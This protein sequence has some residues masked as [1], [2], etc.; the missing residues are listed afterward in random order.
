MWSL[1]LCP[2][3]NKHALAGAPELGTRTPSERY[4]AFEALMYHIE[5]LF[6]IN[7][8]MGREGA[9]LALFSPTHPLPNIR[10]TFLRGLAQ[11]V[12]PAFVKRPV[13]YAAALKSLGGSLA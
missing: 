12:D 6:L 2:P 9:L 3:G 4:L 11:Q 1:L 5:A 13:P 8:K 7:T 10:R